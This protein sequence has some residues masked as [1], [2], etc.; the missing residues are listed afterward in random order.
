M[1]IIVT[2]ST[3]LSNRSYCMSLEMSLVESSELKP[4]KDPKLSIKYLAM[5]PKDSE[6]DDPG[7][8]FILSNQ[9]K[10]HNCVGLPAVANVIPTLQRGGY[11]R[12]L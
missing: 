12:I 4:L 6:S 1:I 9:D 7:I 2:R 5:N 10:I 11:M 8:F 3:R